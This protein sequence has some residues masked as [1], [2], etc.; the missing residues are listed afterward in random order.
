MILFYF[1]GDVITTLYAL[2]IGYKEGNRIV[3]MIL[4]RFGPL[5]FTIAKLLPVCCLFYYFTTTEMNVKTW[6]I[7]ITLA[8]VLGFFATVN[9]LS[10]VM[11][12]TEN[13]ETIKILEF[14][15]RGI[16]TLISKNR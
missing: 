12:L 8:T 5:G 10:A 7:A 4:R 3:A 15:L 1:F 9:N 14:D 11:K 16:R 6:E 2:R 13:K